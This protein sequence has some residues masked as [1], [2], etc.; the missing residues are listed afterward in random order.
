MISSIHIEGFKSIREMTLTLR[1]I[2]I[3]IGAN[4]AGKSN[5][6]SF[7][8]FLNSLYEKR[9]ENYS[10]RKGVENLLYFGSK[11]TP[12][13]YFKIVF[14]N[15]NAYECKLSPSVEG[16]L[17]IDYENIFFNS[18]KGSLYQYKDTWFSRKLS[19]NK[20]ESVLKDNQQSM[21]QYVSTY[22]ESFKNYHFHDTSE[23]APLRKPSSLTDN[24]TLREDGGNLASFLYYLQEKHPS[25]FS[26]IEAVIRMIAPYFERFDL[27]PDRFN[28]TVIKL[29]WLTEQHP[30]IPLNSTHLSDGTLRFM[31]L[32][33]LLMQPSPPEVIIIDEPEL[34][35]HPFA[36]NVLA[37]LI[38][39]A[40]A[41]SQVIIS[42]QSVALVSNFDVA[43]IITVDRRDNQS[44]FS[45]L[46]TDTLSHWIEDFS[47]G[48]LWE[49][50]IINGQPY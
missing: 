28:D 7:F 48:E 3:L 31:A 12:Y 9:L 46:D 8:K 14:S 15:T 5:F 44:V 11:T 4:G 36:I 19:A 37:G 17:F 47:L 22:M 43:D 32:A 39:K 34:G 23:N 20:K 16:T 38:R 2:N 42:T 24:I 40:S 33:T 27:H 26:Q 1:P 30:D 25:Y 41:K 6:I 18:E 21:V 13:I 35:L 49:K 29:E 45:T 50:S 10:L